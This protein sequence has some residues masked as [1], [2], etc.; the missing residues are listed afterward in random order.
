MYVS[1]PTATTQSQLTTGL[2]QPPASVSGVADSGYSALDE[3]QAI[4]PEMFT[5]LPPVTSE[6]VGQITRSS[7]VTTSATQEAIDSLIPN[8]DVFKKPVKVKADEA[9]Q[10]CCSPISPA[11]S[12]IQSSSAP[13]FSLGTTTLVPF[14]EQLPSISSALGQGL[15][16]FSG[17][18]AR[19]SQEYNWFPM[20]TASSSSSC[21]TGTMDTQPTHTISKAPESDTETESVPKAA[22][23][24]IKKDS[25]TEAKPAEEYQPAKFSMRLALKRSISKQS[26]SQPLP[27]QPEAITQI[28]T[29][30]FS[31]SD[32]DEESN[33]FPPKRKRGAPGRRQPR[34]L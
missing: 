21:I 23:L 10:P 27:L 6:N 4:A 14:S 5:I 34:R 19:D 25:T 18:E 12:E 13:S 29:T 3:L 15:S 7:P 16:S 9:Y 24:E 20:A 31:G 28:A 2:A 22:D 11:T 1:A 8:L 17:T 32:T 26:Q 30:E 33:E